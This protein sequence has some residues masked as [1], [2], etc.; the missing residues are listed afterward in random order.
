MADSMLHVNYMLMLIMNRV[1]S[2]N[3]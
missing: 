1:Y 2:T 3:V